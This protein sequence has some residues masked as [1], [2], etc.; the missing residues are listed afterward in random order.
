MREEVTTGTNG[1]LV[2]QALRSASVRVRALVQDSSRAEDLAVAGP[3]SRSPTSIGQTLLILARRRRA[4]AA[5]LRRLISW[6]PRLPAKISEEQDVDPASRHHDRFHVRLIV[7]MDAAALT[8]SSRSTLEKSFADVPRRCCTWPRQE[9]A[10]CR[11]TT[12]KRW[13][14]SGRARVSPR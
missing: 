2:V 6:A 9:I 11:A 3:S 14:G 10:S 4:E 5:A 7:G 13:R 8:P 1:R 12:R